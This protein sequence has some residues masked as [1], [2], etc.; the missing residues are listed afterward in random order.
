MNIA[1]QYS[2]AID[3]E[4]TALLLYQKA[5]L[6]RLKVEKYQLENPD[7]KGDVEFVNGEIKVRGRKDNY[8]THTHSLNTYPCIYV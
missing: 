7:S 2:K 4:N 1:E 8:H 3:T 5:K 6:H